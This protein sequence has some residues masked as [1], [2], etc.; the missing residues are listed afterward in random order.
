MIILL[1]MENSSTYWL[2]SY[3]QIIH[4]NQH[5]CNMS[6]NIK[7]QKTQYIENSSIQIVIKLIS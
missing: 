2:L 4:I 1:I 5:T 6:C 3:L 7:V